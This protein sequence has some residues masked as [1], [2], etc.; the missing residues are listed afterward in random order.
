MAAPAERR[1]EG[2]S[3]RRWVLLAVAGLGVSAVMTQLALLREFLSAFLGNE[4]VLG[5]V[6]GNWLLLTGVG[7]W[8]GR[9][10][11]GVRDPIGRLVGAQLAIALLPLVQM[12]ALRLLRDRVFIRGAEIGLVGT[13][14]SCV[15]LLLPYCVTSGYFLTLACAI[16][17]DPQ[18]QRRD[19]H[20]DHGPCR[21]RRQEASEAVHPVVPPRDLGADN[22]GRFRGRRDLQSLDAHG[23]HE[24]AQSSAAVPAAPGRRDARPTLRF[25]ERNGADSRAA[26]HVYVADAVGSIVGGVLFSFV[27]IHFFDHFSLLSF[28]AMFN[29]GVA[30]AVALAWG[31]RAIAG[32]SVLGIA[33]LL[34]LGIVTD[35]DAWST[36]AQFPGQ[37]VLLRANSPYGRFVVTR[38]D[39]QLNVLE[40]GLP[41]LVT[42]NPERLEETVHYA[43]AQR[44][45]PV[46]VLLV[47]GGASGTAREILKYPVKEVVY[48]ELDPLILEMARRF[49]PDSLRDPRIR[50]VNTDGRRFVQQT[51]ERFDVVILDLP[52]PSTAQLNRFFTAEF[53]AGVRRVLSPAGV[54]GFGVSHY[55]NYVSPELARVLGSVHRTLRT[56]F[57]NDLVI[58]GGR[59]FFLASDG[60]LFTD[61]AARLDRWN[62]ARQFV[63]AHYLDAM[64]AP[65][66]MAD[67]Q[68]AISEPAPVNRDFSP[69]LYYEHL[70]HWLSQF[71]SRLG[72]LQASLAIVFAVCLLRLRAAPLAVFA[73]GFAASALQVVLLLAHQI[74]F[75]SLYQQVG[76]I[77]TVFMAGLASGGFLANRPSANAGAKSLAGLAF[78]LAAL[79]SLLP[80]LS[81][82][83]RTAFATGPGSWLGRIA[84]PVL[85]F[86]LATLVGMQFPVANRL[87][88]ASPALTASRLYTADLMGASLGAFMAS[89]WL[90]PVLG[91]PG[92]CWATA[93]L[94]AWA[95]ANLWWRKD[96]Q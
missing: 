87:V 42:Q 51:A 36:A 17:G 49:L 62:V 77:I 8:L 6:L 45:D 78:A 4:L 96:S 2:T 79:S 82:W 74:V 84:I 28:P 34:V 66:R 38:T 54:F 71:S 76:M 43:M 67:L 58:P 75:G 25:M 29:L 50:P 48:V 35:V 88:K 90:V 37:A 63:T 20:G 65:D 3:G 1:L 95:G 73:S 18:G 47:S 92:M 15:V 10:S 68:R 89:A 22:L 7:T 91:V 56:A 16:L 9:R 30:A 61:I 83:L 59:V 39:G 72:P 64:L 60:P 93:G 57:T 53:F 41:V 52:E 81:P 69:V 14:L 94:N 12:V 27:L 55:E 26:G 85:A 80:L 70:R 24:R 21:R 86:A 33:A 23:D 32:A 40:N 11:A 13:A 19:A 31:R 46:R 5:I 44:P